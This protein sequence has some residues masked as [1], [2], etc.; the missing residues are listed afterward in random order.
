M[1]RNEKSVPWA[2]LAIKLCD[3]FV[4][5]V[6]WTNEENPGLRVI[7]ANHG[8]VQSVELERVTLPL[9]SFRIKNSQPLQAFPSVRA[10]D[11]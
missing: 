4:A 11:S 3:I 6:L 5:G 8:V 2:R 10:V 1:R 7:N 9:R